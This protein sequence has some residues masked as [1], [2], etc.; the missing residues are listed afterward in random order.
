MVG[1]AVSFFNFI[2][3]MIKVKSSFK[4][5]HFGSVVFNGQVRLV[6]TGVFLYF[7]FKNNEVNIIGL[8]VGLTTIAVS[9]PLSMF[10]R[11]KEE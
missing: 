1:W 5:R 11:N 8:L 9:I 7:W 10:F 2:G 6:I 4:N 3:V